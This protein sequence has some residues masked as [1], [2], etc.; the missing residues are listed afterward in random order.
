MS[1]QSLLIWPHPTQSFLSHVSYYVICATAV[2][3][4]LLLSCLSAFVVGHMLIPGLG[5]PFPQIVSSFR[6]QVE[7]CLPQVHQPEVISQSSEVP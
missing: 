3:G 2:L 7:G 1:P 6:N 5:K 4:H